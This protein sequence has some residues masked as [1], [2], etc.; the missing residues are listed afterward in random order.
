MSFSPLL[1]VVAT[2]RND[3]HGANLLA[4]MQLFVNG[5]AE[6]AE[7]YRVAVELIVVEWNP[8]ADR[9]SLADA[10]QWHPGEMFQPQVITVPGEVHHTLANS[11]RLPMYQMIAKNA[12]IRRAGGPYVL[13]TNID[14]LLSDELFDYLKAGLKPNTMYRVDRL[15]VVAP[16][17]APVLPSPA[18]VRAIR[19]IREHGMD[20][21]RYPNDA[22]AALPRRTW[23]DLARIPMAALDRLVLPRLH[24]SGCGDFT[25]TSREVW[26]SLRGYP[27]WPIFSWH[28][29][30]V[31]LYQAHAAGVEMVNL[32]PP[33]VALH[34]E[35]SE[36][37]GWTPEGSSALFNRL[38]QTGVPH[39]STAKY[40]KLVRK[41][42][43]DGRR[44]QPING[45][46]WGLA[47]RKLMATS[48]SG[49]VAM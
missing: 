39:L 4:R 32:Q 16:L 46:D 35:H 19:P 1:S 24:T 14:I 8:P 38:D 28:I 30:G 49:R 12:G 43:R 21:M 6:Q 22:P 15:D 17:E 13:A 36:G 7:R 48:P 20:G 23:R 29:D 37:S 5:F 42:V 31:V 3:N 26:E 44:S 11:A 33:M 25:L 34:L 45:A 47:G 40:R 18:S 2:S 10:M 9:P 41:I 27:E